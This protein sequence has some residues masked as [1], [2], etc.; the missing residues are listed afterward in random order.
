MKVSDIGENELLR[1]FMKLKKEEH[2]LLGPGDDACVLSANSPIFVTVDSFTQKTDFP[3]LMSYQEIGQ[4]ESIILKT[5]R[6]ILV[7]KG[8]C[9]AYVVP[10]GLC[11]A[12]YVAA[13]LALPSDVSMR[14]IKKE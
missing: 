5:A 3:S 12:V 1:S 2:V 13:N 8:C 4:N 7:K 9:E 6:S 14:I 10:T 11:K